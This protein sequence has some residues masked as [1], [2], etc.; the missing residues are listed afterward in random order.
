MPS[1]TSDRAP[2]DRST[3]RLRGRG[4]AVWAYTWFSVFLLVVGS[5]VFMAGGRLHP[6]TD[7]SLGAVGSPEYFETFVQHVLHTDG[8]R[9]MHAALL[10][11]PLLWALGLVALSRLGARDSGSAGFGATGVIAFAMGT[12]C[13]SVVFVIDGFVAPLQA[14]D[15]AAADYVPESI[16]AFRYSQEIVGRLG[17]VSWL[18]IGLG[19]ALVSI[20]L[21]TAGRPG[22]TRRAVVAAPGLLIGL[23]PLA[24]WAVG[25][26][27][28]SVFTSS[29]W[30]TTA[31]VTALWFFLA[32]AVLPT[33]V[34][35]PAHAVAEPHPA[36]R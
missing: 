15:V 8:W 10:T 25:E 36:S 1:Q 24:G 3:A 20:A 16:E 11:G 14:A 23:W 33:L 28:P 18:L 4:A 13:W 29:L 7:H 2:T 32:A 9:E 27:R 19:I 12:V 31:L 34:G 21:L 5:V 30:T 6:S 26:F 22:R 35:R 17:L